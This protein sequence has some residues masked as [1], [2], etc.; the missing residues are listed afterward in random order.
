MDKSMI[1]RLASEMLKLAAEHYCNHGCNEWDWPAWM[2]VQQRADLIRD[3]HARNGDPE[4]IEDDLEEMF[5][6][7]E[8]GPPDFLVMDW[9]GDMLAETAG[10]PGE[11]E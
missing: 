4:C 2:T 8:C 11:E 10:L 3:E 6:G 7:G 5:G 1:L 9:L